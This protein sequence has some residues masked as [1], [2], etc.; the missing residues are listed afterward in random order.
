MQDNRN[1]NTAIIIACF[2]MN[3]SR[4]TALAKCLDK[5]EKQ[6]QQFNLY[7]V[8]LVSPSCHPLPLEITDRCNHIAVEGKSDNEGIWQKESLYNIALESIQDESYVIFM[9]GDVYTNSPDWITKIVSKLSS[10]EKLA[11]QPFRHVIDSKIRDLNFSSVASGFKNAVIEYPA[12]GSGTVWAFR[13]EDIE[14]LSGFNSLYP[15]GCGDTAFIMEILPPSSSYYPHYLKNYPWFI[16]LLRDAQPDIQLDYIDCDLT[17][18]NHGDERHYIDRSSYLNLFSKELSEYYFRNEQ[19]LLE[20]KSNQNDLRDVVKL[21]L[22]K[23]NSKFVNHPIEK[24]IELKKK[25]K[26]KYMPHMPIS[27]GNGK[28]I[29]AENENWLSAER[30]KNNYWLK[31]AIPIGPKSKLYMNLSTRSFIQFDC[32][33]S[34]EEKIYKSDYSTLISKKAP[35]AVKA[36]E[37]ISPPPSMTD[38]IWSIRLWADNVSELSFKI[39]S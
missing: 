22:D 4:V 3:Q 27:L 6:H 35:R 28:S 11:L 33:I 14:Q 31:T 1:L 21:L 26:I 10:T 24:I 16:K 18:I 19:G 2:S 25:G 39:T 36:N 23:L 17:H 29:S 37:I 38:S 9:D 8:E 15:S 5:L 32:D 30:D 7:I 12:H 20:W 34:I 13:R